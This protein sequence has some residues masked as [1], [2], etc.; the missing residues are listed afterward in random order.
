MHPARKQKPGAYTTSAAPLSDRR[1]QPPRAER[2]CP[3]RALSLRRLSQPSS[4]LWASRTPS[5]HDRISPSV[6]TCRLRPTWAAKEGLPSSVS[7]C[8]CLRSSVAGE[9]P[10]PTPVPGHSL[11]PSPRNDGLGHSTFRF[12]I[13]RGCRFAPLVRSHTTSAGLSTHRSGMRVSPQNPEP[14]T[15]CSNAYRGGTSTRKS[16]TA[17]APADPRPVPSWTYHGRNDTPDQCR[18]GRRQK[19]FRGGRLA[20]VRCP[21]PSRSSRRLRLGPRRRGARGQLCPPRFRRPYG[22]E[23]DSDPPSVQSEG[24]PRRPQRRS[25]VQPAQGSLRFGLARVTIREWRARWKATGNA[26]LIP[27]HPLRRRGRVSPETVELVRRA[28]FDLG[29]GSGKTK[30]W[31]ERVH[32]VRRPPSNASCAI[33]GCPASA[34]GSPGVPNSSELDAAARLGLSH[35]PPRHEADGRGRRPYGAADRLAEGSPGA[36]RGGWR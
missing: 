26:G 25:A 32:N 22:A 36:A 6:Y 4:L 8:P 27:R 9:C 35:G 2:A 21:A 28:R 1:R 30:I 13:A 15:R 5:R 16:H 31:L 34:A 10:V 20:A 23:C 19:A 3:S 18:D 14:A 11:P 24:T 12:R 17:L 7:G 29:Y 33:S